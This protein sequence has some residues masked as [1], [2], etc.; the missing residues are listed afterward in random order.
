MIAD[1]G[2]K[3]GKNFGNYAPRFTNPQSEIR[4]PQFLIPFKLRVFAVRFPVAVMA[5]VQR[6]TCGFYSRAFCQMGD[7]DMV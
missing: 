1:C 5:H 2:M 3:S 6:N 7:L 4:I